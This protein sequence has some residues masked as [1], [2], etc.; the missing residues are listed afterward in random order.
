MA[1]GLSII[2]VVLYAGSLS[3]ADVVAA[4]ETGWYIWLL[5]VSFSDYPVPPLDLTVP[6]PPP[7]HPS[8]AG[9][10]GAS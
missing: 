1:L 6:P 4:Q 8:Q 3:T 2:G 10:P 7:R 5:P 9:E